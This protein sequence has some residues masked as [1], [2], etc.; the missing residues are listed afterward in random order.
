MLPKLMKRR[1]NLT[2]ALCL[3]LLVTRHYLSVFRY[4]CHT[5]TNDHHYEYMHA[6]LTLM[7][8]LKKLD[9]L[10]LEIHEVGHQECFTIDKDVISH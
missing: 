4:T 8:I 1:S 9:R 6:Q 3:I 7:S 10:D 2:F 5:R